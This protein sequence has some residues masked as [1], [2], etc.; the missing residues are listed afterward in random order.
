MQCQAELH[1][2]MCDCAILYQRVARCVQAFQ[3]GRVLTAVIYY[4][5]HFVSVH[6]DISVAMNRAWRKKGAG[7]RR[8]QL[9]IH[10]FPDL[11]CSKIYERT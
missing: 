7:L 11:Q 10:G 8:Y 6:K 5:G 1:D 2:A 3:S 9:S 4:S